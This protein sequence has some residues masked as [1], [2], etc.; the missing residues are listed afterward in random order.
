MSQ[1]TV[2]LLERCGRKS[3]LVVSDISFWEISAKVSRG[4]LTLSIDS[5]IW[6]SRAAKAPGIRFL[7][8]DRDTLLLSTR[9]TGTIHN[10]PAD[11]ILLAITQ[12]N[13]IPLVSVDASIIDYARA[14]PGTPVVDARR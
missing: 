12:L 10:D 1:Y 8:L 13:N 4:R 7:P 11:R 2:K 9:L 14:N 5:G 3:N 6:L